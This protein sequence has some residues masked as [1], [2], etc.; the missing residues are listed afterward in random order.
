MS[1]ILKYELCIKGMKCSNCSN[2]VEAKLKEIQ[3]VESS[4]VNLITEKDWNFAINLESL[5]F[6]NSEIEFKERKQPKF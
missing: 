1:D 2:K 5:N 4:S 3:G 6:V